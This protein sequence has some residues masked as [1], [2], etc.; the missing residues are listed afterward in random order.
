MEMIIGDII[1]MSYIAN[2]LLGY[3]ITVLFYINI[4][5]K[6]NVLIVYVFKGD[7]TMDDFNYKN[8]TKIIFGKDSFSEIGKNIKIFSKKT[9]KILL[10][11]ER[12]E[13]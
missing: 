8:D 3:F 9:P 5:R 4:I 12:M 6:Q 13:N 7:G 2:I 1:K 11:Y 10:H